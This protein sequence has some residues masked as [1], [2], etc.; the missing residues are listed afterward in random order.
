MGRLLGRLLGGP[1]ERKSVVAWDGSWRK[2]NVLQRY[3]TP[4]SLPPLLPALPPLVGGDFVGEGRVLWDGRLALGEES[5][6]HFDR[7]I[8]GIQLLPQTQSILLDTLSGLPS[9]SASSFLARGK[10]VDHRVEILEP[11]KCGFGLL[12]NQRVFCLSFFPRLQRLLPLLP[13]LPSPPAP[14]PPSPSLSSSL[15]TLVVLPSS[16]HPPILNARQLTHHS[17]Q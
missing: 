6:E 10:L 13:L 9:L 12:L 16:L 15:S 2:R 8:H 17:H 11:R 5:L 4:P 14:P 1:F 3:P 7:P